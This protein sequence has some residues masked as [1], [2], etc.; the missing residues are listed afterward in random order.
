MQPVPPNSAGDRSES[1]DDWLKSLDPNCAGWD[2]FHLIRRLDA[3]FDREGFPRTGWSTRREGD[4][5]HLG[6]GPFLEFAPRSIQQWSLTPVDRS[7]FGRPVLLVYFLGLFGPNGPLPIHLTEYALDRERRRDFT[8]SN[9]A[10]IFQ[11]RFLALF[12]RAWAA[13][14][15]EVD[16]DR[17]GAR[18]P[19]WL[20]CL[21]GLRTGEESSAESPGQPTPVGDPALWHLWMARHRFAG[22]FAG[23]TRH[24][25]GLASILSGF[26]G[27]PIRIETFRPNWMTVPK[28]METRLGDPENGSLGVTALLG[29]RVWEC[30]GEFR[31]RMGPLSLE[32]LERLLP[33]TD[34]YRQVRAIV[35]EYA[36]AELAWDMQL[37]LSGHEV[38]AL[39]LNGSR[40]LGYTTFLS[41]TGPSSR[42]A[43][44]SP[45]EAL[46]DVQTIV[47]RPCWDTKPAGT[48]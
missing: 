38:P 32:Q 1:L 25:E 46:P 20:G 11:H 39:G 34:G 4:A 23:R 5:V 10:N 7:Q 2:F 31:V 47:F 16:F 48:A 44:R 43:T 35:G 28:G 8:F 45:N 26:L 6:Q 18:F 37:V 22:Q 14:R 24:A 19:V 33:G 40:R 42:A 17:T 12:Y 27:V 15:I 13:P 29:D 9:F 36:P 41:A 21:A 3:V 30:Q